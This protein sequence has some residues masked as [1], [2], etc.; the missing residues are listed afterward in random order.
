MKIN[1]IKK[2]EKRILRSVECRLSRNIDYFHGMHD[3]KNE[4]ILEFQKQNVQIV[5][6]YPFEFK[7]WHNGTSVFIVITNEGKK[8][9]VKVRTYKVVKGKKIYSDWSNV[10]SVKVR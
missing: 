7:K 2:I 9:F 6:F 8:Y 10:K 5:S 3:F 4:I 1:K